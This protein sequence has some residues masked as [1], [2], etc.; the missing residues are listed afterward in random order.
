MA[1]TFPDVTIFE[2][3]S[4]DRHAVKIEVNEYATVKPSGYLIHRGVFP[5]QSEKTVVASIRD[6]FSAQGRPEP[7]IVRRPVG[8]IVWHVIGLPEVVIPDALP[9]DFGA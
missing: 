6:Y 3:K 1:N 8:S 2:P 9:E 4:D 5:A 7:V